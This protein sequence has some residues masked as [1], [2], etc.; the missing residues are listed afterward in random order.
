M[1]KSRLNETEQRA[2]ATQTEIV[3]VIVPLST[4]IPVYLNP[5][6]HANLYPLRSICFC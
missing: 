2:L 4:P 1:E 6:V 5:Y 3:S